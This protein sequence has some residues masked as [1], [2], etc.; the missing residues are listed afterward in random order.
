LEIGIRINSTLIDVRSESEFNEDAI[1]N[2]V[3]VPLLNDYNRK[4]VGFIYKRQNQ[5]SKLR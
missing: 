4:I 1:P 5:I 3:N 2:A